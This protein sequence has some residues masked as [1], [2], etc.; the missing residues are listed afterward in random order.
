MGM[1]DLVAR[2]LGAGEI[3]PSEAL[4]VGSFIEQR[5]KIIETHELEK[6]LQTLEERR[7]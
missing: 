1:S 4:D 3:T 6:R 2:K 7:V 5:R